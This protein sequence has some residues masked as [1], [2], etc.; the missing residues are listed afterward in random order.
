MV[1]PLPHSRSACTSSA[2]SGSSLADGSPASLQKAYQ[3]KRGAQPETASHKIGTFPG[4]VLLQPAAVYSLSQWAPCQ[5]HGGESI[6][7]SFAMYTLSFSAQAGN[8]AHC[9]AES[10]AALGPLYGWVTAPT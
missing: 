3:A 9:N 2:C 6:G 7:T 10:S 8:A 5:C 4:K 1:G